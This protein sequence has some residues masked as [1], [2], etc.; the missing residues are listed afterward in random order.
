MGHTDFSADSPVTNGYFEASGARIYYEVTGT[1]YPLVLLHAG[2]L[3]GRMWDEQ[4]TAYA[5]TY[6]VIRYDIPAC[7]RS[8]A[9][10]ESFS[11]AG[12]LSVLLKHLGVNQAHLIGASLGGRIAIDFALEYPAMVNALILV[13]PGLGGYQWSDEYNRQ[14]GV[15]FSAAEK[16][17]PLQAVE[18]WLKHPHMLPAMENSTLSE[19]IRQM[20]LDNANLWTQPLPEK[21]L[22]PPAV[23]RLKSLH[24]PTQIMVGDRDVPDIHAIADLITADVAGASKVM[25]HGAGHLISME[26]PDEFN[27]AV[28]DFL[29]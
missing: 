18:E 24:I 25:F 10:T 3:D 21:P 14:I 16:S 11:D 2:G 17:G 4:F 6:T 19:R 27:Q 8:S 12:I 22:D 20:N 7:G 15:I 26:M 28:L 29:K 1:G 13:A 9:P 5:E 23:Q